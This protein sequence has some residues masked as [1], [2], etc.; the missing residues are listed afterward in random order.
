L[1]SDPLSLNSFNL[2][3]L[4]FSLFSLVYAVCIELDQF[5]NIPTKQL[6]LSTQDFKQDTH[7]LLLVHDS[8]LLHKNTKPTSVSFWRGA[9]AAT[10][11]FG[12]GRSLGS[13]CKH[14]DAKRT[15]SVPS[16][17]ENCPSK[18]ESVSI[19][20]FLPRI[21][22]SACTKFYNNHICKF[23]YSIVI[24]NWLLRVCC[25][26]RIREW[27]VRFWVD[28]ILIREAKLGMILQP[29]QP[30]FILINILNFPNLYKFQGF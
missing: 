2:V 20:R 7:W 30:S 19:W 13:Y 17:S 25:R 27:K 9:K 18:Q 12:L 16:S 10:N 26:W 21:T 1:K 5:M 28:F 3:Y 14:R 15:N 8:L 4:I 6:A 29:P 24:Y 22:S 11:D 23:T